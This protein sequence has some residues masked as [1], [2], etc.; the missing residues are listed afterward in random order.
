M[1]QGP[2]FWAPPPPYMVWSDSPA[3]PQEL[4]SR[5]APHPPR[6]GSHSFFREHLWGSLHQLRSNQGSCKPAWSTNSKKCKHAIRLAN[7]MLCSTSAHHQ[8]Y[9]SIK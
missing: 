5:L 6:D 1:Y 2:G 7:T 9:I 3:L 8:I 4:A